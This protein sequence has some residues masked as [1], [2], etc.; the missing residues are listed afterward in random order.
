MVT[1][2]YLF[3]AIGMIVFAGVVSGLVNAV[4]QART[5]YTSVKRMRELSEASERAQAS[6]LYGIRW[7]SEGV[8]R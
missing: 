4:W 7:G 3:G 1:W 5:S 8:G 2:M 6:A